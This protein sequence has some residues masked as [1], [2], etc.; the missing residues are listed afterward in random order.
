MQRDT[1]RLRQGE[2]HV[3][4]LP[5]LGAAGYHWTVRVEGDAESVDVSVD[6]DS[7]LD[8]AE[9]LAGASVD[10]RATI[11]GRRRGAA[12]VYLEQRRPWEREGTP[13]DRRTIDVEVS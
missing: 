5:G 1:L 2:Q 13:V 4:R 9:L 11:S 7:A 3:V 12:T 10:E 6:T 8:R